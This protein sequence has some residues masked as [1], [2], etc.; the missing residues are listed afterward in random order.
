VCCFEAIPQM[1]KHQCLVLL[2]DVVPHRLLHCH[3]GVEEEV[4]ENQGRGPGPGRC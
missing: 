3:W 2:L 4:P 1:W